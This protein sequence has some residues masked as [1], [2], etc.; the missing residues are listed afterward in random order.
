MRSRW[1]YS[2]AAALLLALSTAAQA[3]Q[4]SE[5]AATQPSGRTTFGDWA[6]Q[7]E[8]A[9]GVAERCYLIETVKAND[10]PVMVVIVAYSPKRER[11][12]AMIDVP[13]G[14]HIPTGLE[15]RA[16]GTTKKVDF[17]QCLPTG[18]RAMLPIDDAL[19]A[20][21]KSGAPAAIAGRGSNG[22]NIELPISTAGFKEA[23]GAL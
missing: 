3:Q 18:C 15:V 21:L 13:L 19:L 17:E 4:A 12:A 2:I 9:P 6:K 1:T 20:A 23:F 10:K 8:A 16:N 14:M 22:A 11:V 7:C 5:Q